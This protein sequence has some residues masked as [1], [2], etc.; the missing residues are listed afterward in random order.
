MKI[1][2]I[3][4]TLSLDRCTA[5]ALCG[6]AGAAAGCGLIPWY[7]VIPVFAVLLYLARKVRNYALAGFLL[8]LSSG[9]IY[10]AEHDEI[11]ELFP[12]SGM[13]RGTLII[14][15]SRAT[16]VNGIVP[17]S[18]LRGEF[19]PEEHSDVV[20]PVLAV[21]PPELKKSGVLYGDRFDVTGILTVP[22]PGGFYFDGREIS[23]TVPPPYGENYLLTVE[24]AAALET[25]SG[26]KRFCFLVREKLLGRLISGMK[27]PESR[28]MAARLFLGASDGGSRI[29]RRNFVLS[30]IIHLF[31]VSG[32][33]VGILALVCGTALGFLP[34]RYRNIL[35]A[36]IVALYVMF[37]GLA[38]PALRAGAMIAVWCLLRAFLF[39]TP[40]WNILSLSF[41]V[42]CI[43]D[44]GSVGELGTLYSYGITAA[45]ILGLSRLR[46]WREHAGFKF[47]FM[48]PTAQYTW[49]L[50]KR[51]LRLRRLVSLLSASSIAFAASS[52]LT[53]YY[54]NLFLPGSILTN[55]ATGLITPL[56][57]GVFVLKMCFCSFFNIFDRIAGTVLESGFALLKGVS[58]LSLELFDPE[59]SSTPPVWLAVL[60]YLLLFT[61]LAMRKFPAALPFL[62]LAAA[63][64]LLFPPAKFG[65]PD[66]IMILG[67]SSGHPPLAVYLIPDQSRAVVCNLPES[68]SSVLAASEIRKRGCSEVEIFFSA[69][70]SA[71]SSGLKSFS[72]R[73]A[74]AALHMPA[75]KI[76]GFFR[77]NI[78]AVPECAGLMNHN[79]ADP[80]IPETADQEN[81][82]KWFPV[83][84]AEVAAVRA[85]DGW[86]ISG[87]FPGGKTFSSTVPWC[88]QVLIFSCVEK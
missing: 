65:Q 50:R 3:L 42:L 63:L 28:S 11:S 83:P 71:N 16:R 43:V 8:A 51:Q 68:W 7:I 18:R 30:G 24:S 78:S 1:R 56:M 81:S 27:N 67:G 86:R 57:F 23:G 5:L 49:D 46:D 40:N 10:S 12:H 73:L 60:F 69:G 32:M 62:S 29:D 15:D 87:K 79:T 31:A 88:N 6:G 80:R 74:P 61:G 59:I 48:I 26:F 9:I 21:L 44:P 38:V 54:N 84:G 70:Y 53:M 17:E 47:E 39:F 25:G 37:S 36:V 22:G 66:E 85:D 14:V 4:E 2:E 41:F 52:M 82:L 72:S 55:I 76:T 75:G 58:E 33:H 13:Q 34:F 45:L 35:L 19:I 64:L 20:I 77:K